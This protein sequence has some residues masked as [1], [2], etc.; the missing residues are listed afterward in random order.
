MKALLILFAALVLVCETQAAQKFVETGPGYPR[1]I[2]PGTL[3]YNSYTSVLNSPTN[4]IKIKFNCQEGQLIPRLFSVTVVETNRLDPYLTILPTPGET[5]DCNLINGWLCKKNTSVGKSIVCNDSAACGKWVN[6]D[7]RTV[8]FFEC[9]IHRDSSHQEDAGW[10]EQG[11]LNDYYYRQEKTV[12]CAPDKNSQIYYFRGGY[13]L[14]R[15]NTPGEFIN[16]QKCDSA[17]N[18]DMNFADTKYANLPKQ[19]RVDLP[20]DV[21]GVRVP[22]VNRVIAI[23]QTSCG[24]SLFWLSQ[25]YEK[26]TATKG[27]LNS[28]GVFIKTI[29]PVRGSEYVVAHVAE[30][31]SFNAVPLSK[32]VPG[33]EYFFAHGDSIYL[34]YKNEFGLRDRGVPA[35][36]RD[37][38]CSPLTH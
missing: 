9:M 19:S 16:I 7:T 27:I 8:S 31:E 12:K 34:Q 1:N 11:V 14:V 24:E 28:Q 38:I 29:N 6:L 23:T 26:N 20:V 25:K 13:F 36:P 2:C 33:F 15:Q 5:Y 37:L 21:Y 35:D 32:G 18:L 4:Q 30:I 17:G 3:V 10:C 22:V